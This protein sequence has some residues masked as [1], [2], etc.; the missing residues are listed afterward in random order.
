MQ[1]DPAFYVCQIVFFVWAAVLLGC[2][3]KAVIDEVAIH[4]WTRSGWFLSPRIIWL[5]CLCTTAGLFMVTQFDPR[6]A[7]GIFNTPIL[8]FVEWMT[9]VSLL[10]SIA[11]TAY[12]Y[13][14]VMF[15]QNMNSMPKKARNFWFGLNLS[16]IFVHMIV[17]LI[18]SIGNNSRW[19]TADS[20]LL[21]VHEAILICVLYFACHKLAQGLR[22]QTNDV[23][24]IGDSS[25]FNAALRK[26]CLVRIISIV[27][28]AFAT[29]FQLFIPSGLI[30]KLASPSATTELTPYQAYRFSPALLVTPILELGLLS[31]LL[32][33]C[34]RPQEKNDKSSNSL[35]KSKDSNNPGSPRSGSVGATFL[36]V[37]LASEASNP[38]VTTPR[39][40]T[41]PFVVLTSEMGV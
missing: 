15:R 13:L 4:G 36:R 6:G 18:G 35:P 1:I 37:S 20:V 31:F 5:L 32:Y 25:N 39:T 27:V 29:A 23:N 38:A 24:A 17:S 14:I 11:L 33:M 40:A 10:V 9:L 7:L 21:L 26:L 16:F 22:K 28:Y 41:T 30:D 2:F 34:Q 3:I 19:Y 8:K 12:M